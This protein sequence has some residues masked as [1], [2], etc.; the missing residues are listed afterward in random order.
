M[1]KLSIIVPC[2][3]EA[4]TIEEILRRIET[5][6]VPPLWEKEVIVVD[7]ASTDGTRDILRLL[8]SRVRV[9]YCEHNGGKGTAFS[10]GLAVATG[11]HMVTQDADLEYDPQEIQLLLEP[12]IAGRADAV[13][14]SRT[15]RPQ[16]RYGSLV[17]RMGVWVLTKLINI[18]WNLKLTD[19][20]AGYKL[21]PAAAAP[22]WRTGRF[23]SDIRFAGALAQHG[24]T[25]AEVPIH[26][27][28][29]AWNEGK[30]IRYHDGLRAIVA[31]VADWLRHL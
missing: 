5:A 3:N 28:P 11:T 12:I 19:A 8:E 21:F 22:L 25:I 14:G 17:A 16:E 2:Y 4:R 20:C 24:F 7:D 29:R 10:R 27:R 26:Y 31:I 6:P 13:Y 15:L 9:L 18:L 1:H 30:K 23:D